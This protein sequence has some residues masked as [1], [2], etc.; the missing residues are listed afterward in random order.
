MTCE[1]CLWLLAGYWAIHGRLVPATRRLDFS[2]AMLPGKAMLQL[3]IQTHPFIALTG[4][5]N[6]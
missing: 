6:K 5:S 4:E 2:G 1:G 3:K